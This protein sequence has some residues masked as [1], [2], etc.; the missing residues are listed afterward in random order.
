GLVLPARGTAQV[1]GEQTARLG[2]RGARRL[3]S[4]IGFVHQDLALVDALRVV[5]NVNAGNLGR[6]STVSALGSLA[7]PRAAD[8]A[9]VALARVG[10]ADKIWTRTDQLSGGQR[11]RVAIAR[12][13]VQDPD[14]VLA[15]EPAANLDPARAREVARLL[16]ET[17]ATPERALVMSLHNV[18]LALEVCDRVVGLRLGRKLFDGRAGEVT[19][20]LL[21]GLYESGER[22]ET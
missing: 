11:Q 4:R 3:R 19:E 5:H 17:A 10:I 20:T 18:Q 16:V 12:T 1:L 13:L 14:L 7:R 22:R 2:R 6:W 21:D 9:R 15:D 8:E